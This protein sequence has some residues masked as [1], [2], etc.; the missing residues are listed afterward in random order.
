MNDF[1]FLIRGTSIEVLLFLPLMSSHILESEQCGCHG[2]YTKY[3]GHF[4]FQYS[5]VRK[6]R[7]VL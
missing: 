4:Y 6:D 5:R 1:L 2:Y 7:Q 3:G